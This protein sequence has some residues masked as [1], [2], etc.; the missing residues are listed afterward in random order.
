MDG[1]QRTGVLFVLT[2]PADPSRVDDFNDWYVAYGEAMERIGYLAQPVRF[3]NPDAAGNERDP[4]FAAVYDIVTPDPATVWP[5]TESSTDYPPAALF[6]DPRSK[7]VVPAF[8]ASYALVGAA[9]RPDGHGTLTG[10]YLALSTGGDD[11]VR[12]RWESQILESG[13]FYAVSRFRAIEG[14][15][16]VAATGDGLPEPPGWLEVFE[17]DVR[18]PLTAYAQALKKLAPELPDPQ[19]RYQTTGAYRL[20][21]APTPPEKLLAEAR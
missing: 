19:I 4:R 20:V 6:D 13:L 1:T 15:A 17:T 7:L 8:R 14:W 9:Q 5:D 11:T 18:E 21:S 16:G 10:V 3:E 2:N 12:Q